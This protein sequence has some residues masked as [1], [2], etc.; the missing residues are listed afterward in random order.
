VAC[1]FWGRI[2]LLL[3]SLVLPV[4]CFALDIR[5]VQ[6]C[7]G[8]VLRLRGDI[9]VG[10]FSHLRSRIRKEAIIGFDLSS[11][12]GDFEEGLRIADL[13]RRR[14]LSVY[15]AGECD[16][17]C[18]DVFFAASKRFVG[19]DS[20]IGVHS[21]S[22]DRDVE[23]MESKR[24]TMK[25]AKFWAKQG[26]PKSAIRKMVTTRPETITYLDQT[27]LSGLQASAGNPFAEDTEVSD[28]AGEA[29]QQSCTNESVA[30]SG[31]RHQLLTVQ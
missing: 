17:A 23:D 16:S 3:F 8:A 26:I 2:L 20:K 30:G 14:K 28:A 25:L 13:T 12:G 18:A 31:L 29:H 19:E 21:V 22:N 27:D 5:R 10:D 11:D 9:K 15:V 7:L 6:T 1:W 4:T 24:L